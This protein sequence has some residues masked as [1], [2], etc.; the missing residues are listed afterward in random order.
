MRIF[1]DGAFGAAGTYSDKMSQMAGANFVCFMP[2]ATPS[3]THERRGER[4]SNLYRVTVYIVKIKSWSE[5]GS[6]F[7][8]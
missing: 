4:R 1:C 6:M 7:G 8:K 2:H 5:D 3:H